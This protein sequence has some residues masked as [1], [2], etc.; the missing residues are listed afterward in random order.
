MSSL[1]SGDVWNIAVGVLDLSVVVIVVV[2]CGVEVA[3]GVDPI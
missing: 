2:A 3:G 1:S